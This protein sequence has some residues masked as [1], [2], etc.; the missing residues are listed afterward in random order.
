[1]QAV[2][3]AITAFY[4]KRA[5]METLFVQL[6]NISQFEPHPTTAAR[7]ISWLISSLV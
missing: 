3:L 6:K 1:V 2:E 7:G 4:S 5:I